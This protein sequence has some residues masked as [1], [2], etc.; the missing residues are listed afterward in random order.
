MKNFTCSLIA[1]VLLSLTSCEKSKGDVVEL[2]GGR[3]ERPAARFGEPFNVVEQ[4]VK[5]SVFRLE[6]ARD[7]HARDNVLLNSNTAPVGKPP[8]VSWLFY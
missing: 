2:I 8:A 5:H 3:R 4:V 6:N 7:F 1:L